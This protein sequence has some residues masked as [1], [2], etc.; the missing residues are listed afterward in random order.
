[1]H[2]NQRLEHVSPT[3]DVEIRNPTAESA[4]PPA[5]THAPP[6]CPSPFA[7]PSTRLALPRGAHALTDCSRPCLLAAQTMTTP[8]VGLVGSRVIDND[9]QSSNKKTVTEFA[10]PK[11]SR[12]P[13]QISIPKEG[14]W[15]NPN[16]TVTGDCY[17]TSVEDTNLYAS[18]HAPHIE[19][20]SFFPANC[21]F[22]RS[23]TL[24]VAMRIAVRQGEGLLPR[25]HCHVRHVHAAVRPINRT[26]LHSS[27]FTC[28]RLW[29]RRPL[30]KWSGGWRTDTIIKPYKPTTKSQNGLGFVRLRVFCNKIGFYFLTFFRCNL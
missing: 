6:S 24:S 11:N 8:T 25:R 2:R 3:S 5:H 21:F 23:L 10:F 7:S 19:N 14:A 12:T 26:R 20:C 28:L 13:N 16:T 27:A 18:L 1:M 15:P 22:G 17:A 29:L 30:A 9:L 4:C